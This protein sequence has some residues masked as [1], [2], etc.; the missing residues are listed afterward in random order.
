M[1]RKPYTWRREHRCPDCGAPSIREGARCHPCSV[2]RRT[3]SRRTYQAEYHAEHRPSPKPIAQAERDDFPPFGEIVT[4]DERIQCHVC[5]RWFGS[6]AGHV[7]AHGH[8]AETYKAAFGLARTSSL[9][10]PSAQA[11]QRAAAIARDQG[12]VGREQLAI[13]DPG[14]RPKGIDARLQSRI[15]SSLADRP[16]RQS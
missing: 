3:A 1:A 14:G 13:M 6:L 16:P 5:G 12:A 7:R 8:N 10:G 4:D 15:R 9:L 11:K 2:A